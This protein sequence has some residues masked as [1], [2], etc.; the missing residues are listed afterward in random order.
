MFTASRIRELLEALNA[1]LA[2]EDVRG[3]M[4]MAGG[5]MCPVFRA[6]VPLVRYVRTL[7]ALPLPDA[8]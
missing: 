5:V 6:R 7:A 8:I 4:F 3:E 2:R 1:E